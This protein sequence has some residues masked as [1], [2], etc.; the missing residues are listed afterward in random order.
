MGRLPFIKGLWILAGFALLIPLASAQAAMNVSGQPDHTAAVHRSAHV[1]HAQRAH[2][3]RHLALR[4]HGPR[5]EAHFSAL[6]AAA[7]DAA[8]LPQPGGRSHPGHHQGAM[9]R[10]VC[11]A[12]RLHDSRVGGRHAVVP[13]AIDAGAPQS[14]L[15]LSMVAERRAGALQGSVVSGRGPPRAGPKRPFALSASP[16]LS[17][18]FPSPSVSTVHPERLGSESGGSVPARSRALPWSLGFV[19][20]AGELQPPAIHAERN[21]SASRARRVEGTAPRPYPP[22]SGETA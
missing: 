5:H 14:G 20:P 15:R 18:P 6:P 13:P 17:R 19:V 2:A 10:H 21:R 1:R 22:S 9:P 11:T 4:H 7:A 12:H 3:A 8:G 16:P